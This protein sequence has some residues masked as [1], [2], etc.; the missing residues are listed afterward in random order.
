MKGIG[1]S[2]K[3]KSQVGEGHD[4]IRPIHIIKIKSQAIKK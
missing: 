2:K 3:G 1:K 4:T